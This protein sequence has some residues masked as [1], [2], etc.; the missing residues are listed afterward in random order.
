M[1]VELL[2]YGSLLYECVELAFVFCFIQMLLEKLEGTQPR[3]LDSITI[4]ELHF[5]ESIAQAQGGNPELVKHFLF[6]K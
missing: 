6:C 4:P 2:S 1:P 3:L 5:D